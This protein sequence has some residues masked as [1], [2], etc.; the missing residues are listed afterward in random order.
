MMST[1]EVD[2]AMDEADFTDAQAV[3]EV[4]VDL[5]RCSPAAVTLFRSDLEQCG[6]TYT[7]LMRHEIEPFDIWHVDDLDL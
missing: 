7:P 4:P 6:A 1:G 3:V 2:G 5:E